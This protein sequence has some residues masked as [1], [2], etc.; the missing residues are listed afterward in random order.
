M[1]MSQIN[2]SLKLC[3]ENDHQT[4]FWDFGRC[5]EK[6]SKIQQIFRKSHEQ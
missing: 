5:G 4:I 1:S 6:K 3:P 2:S